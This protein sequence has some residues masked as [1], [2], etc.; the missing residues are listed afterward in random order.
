MR[1]FKICFHGIAS[2]A[3]NDTTALSLAVLSN[4]H[5]AEVAEGMRRYESESASQ[6]QAT[7]VITA[8]SGTLFGLVL[9]AVLSAMY[10]R[11]AGRADTGAEIYQTGLELQ[12][13]ADGGLL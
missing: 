2:I 8:A 10:W 13:N 4:Q 5:A 6:P 3:A 7:V 9:A 1:I 12:P 11:R